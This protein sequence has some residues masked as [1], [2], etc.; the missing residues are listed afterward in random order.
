MARTFV[1]TSSSR[2]LYSASITSTDY[3]AGMSL[4]A[5]FRPAT[6]GNDGYPISMRSGGGTTIW[7]MLLASGT[8]PTYEINGG[9]VTAAGFPTV[10]AN[11]WYC[12]VMSKPA[13]TTVARLH[14]Y[15]Y[16][17]DTWTHANTSSTTALPSG[18][19]SSLEIGAQG[20][21]ARYFDGD[22]AATA[23][24]TRELNDNTC[25]SL[26]YSLQSWVA[27][28]PFGL[29]VLD[30]HAT[31]QAVKDWTGRFTSPTD[32][33]TSISANSVPVFSYG[34]PVIAPTC[35]A[36]PWLNQ[37]AGI[38]ARNGT[39]SHTI[40]FGFTST[41]G[42]E[43]V[44]I[45]HGAVT[46]T[47]PSGD[48]NKRLQ[49]VSSGEMA[50]FTRTSAGDSS[51][52]VNHNGS[53]YPVT[54][55]AYEL[56]A[57]STWTDGTGSNPAS[58]TFPTLSGLPGTA[59]LIIAARGRVV[60]GT[61][62]DAASTVWDAPSV[63]DS[64]LFT[65]GA[66]TDGTY[67]TVAHQTDATATGVTPTASTSYTG[68][69]AADRQHVVFAFALGG[70]GGG[71]TTHNASVT[72]GATAALTGTATT[73]TSTT[74]TL[75][76][77][78]AL[79]GSGSAIRNASGTLAGTAA[80]TVTGA[81][82]VSGTNTLVGTGTLTASGSV[83]YSVTGSLTGAGALTASA[84]VVR[85]ATA[86]MAGTGQLTAAGT[87][88]GSSGT[89]SLDGTAA[90]TATATR[91]TSGTSTA[92]GA[93]SLTAAGT[94]ALA[95]T[96]GAAGTGSLITAAA[97]GRNADSTLAGAA[98]MT[99]AGTPVRVTATTAAGTGGLTAAASVTGVGGYADLNG[100]GGLTAAATAALSGTASMAGMSTLSGAASRST[101]GSVTSGGTGSLAAT[102]AVVRVGLV[103]M[104]GTAVVS[105]VADT[106]G[107]ANSVALAGVGGLAGSA[108]RTAAG[109]G[110]IAGAGGLTAT[111]QVVKT[112]TVVMA[113]LGELTSAAVNPRR[114]GVF[115]AG[116]TRSRLTAGTIRGPI[117]S[118]GTVTPTTPF[119][120][121]GQIATA[122]LGAGVTTDGDIAT[123]DL[124][125]TGSTIDINVLIVPVGG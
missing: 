94:L 42:N 73:V 11:T 99:A 52:T 13:G 56:P 80:L 123:V 114:P 100:M 104:A 85:P 51:I 93:G 9:T 120:A 84:A 16:G 3:A 27:A 32:T 115:T 86:A 90:L 58:D 50:V 25:E 60:T 77:T 12:L 33:A 125:L 76:G 7:G 64:D 92:A 21:F 54:W 62:T 101:M 109:A 122:L 83:A 6:T 18:T 49:P 35:I 15:N 119:S 87:V 112:A 31:T 34:H 91:V 118:S 66:A 47:D 55:A 82:S 98:G 108:Q 59:Q 67:L 43:L 29:W 103:A 75:T 57:G 24:F 74:S 23:M 44:V 95:G 53:N 113:G 8:T 89:V 4:A 28:D 105:A 88:A 72:S 79:T 116:T 110:P 81:L 1:R 41:S 71:P 37:A 48:W 5:I 107:G 78:G 26:A 19:A 121:S 65:L 17:T 10:S 70:G 69:F 14:L 39:N 117:Y 22:V 61:T 2:I 97:V 20:L 96:S 30:Q 38:A 36:T 111:A 46:H 63:E 68:V 124:G 40:P 45:V 102:A 106:L